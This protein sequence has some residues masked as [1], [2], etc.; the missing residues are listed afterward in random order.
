MQ[1]V[2][3]QAKVAAMSNGIH[4]ISS[5]TEP[6]PVT[7]QSCKEYFPRQVSDVAGRSAVIFDPKVRFAFL[8]NRSKTINVV[9]NLATTGAAPQNP[10][11][12]SGNGTDSL[13]TIAPI[14]LAAARFDDCF[15]AFV[16]RDQATTSNLP[17][18]EDKDVLELHVRSRSP[19][20]GR[21]KYVVDLTANPPV[22]QNIPDN[23]EEH[24]HQTLQGLGLEAAPTDEQTWVLALI[25]MVCPVPPG[26]KIPEG[27]ALGEPLPAGETYDPLFRTWFEALSHLHSANE[28]KPLSNT[29][30]LFDY[31]GEQITNAAQA[32]CDKTL[33]LANLGTPFTAVNNVAVR[34][35]VR[36][37]VSARAN[38]CYI[39]WA[40]NN[41]A[42]ET[43]PG[44]PPAPPNGGGGGGGGTNTVLTIKG[45][46]AAFQAA[47]TARENRP[48]SD[49]AA[50]AKR[51]D[52]LTATLQIIGSKKSPTG[53]IVL[54][55]VKTEFA[56]VIGLPRKDQCQ[57]FQRL[58]RDTNQSLE[59]R[60]DAIAGLDLTLRASQID[61][62]FLTAFLAAR[63]ACSS[64]PLMEESEMKTDLSVMHLLSVKS[65]CAT[66]KARSEA[67]IERFTQAAQTFDRNSQQGIR[68]IDLYYSGDQSEPRSIIT[69]NNWCLLLD[70]CLENFTESTFYQMTQ[71]F[72]KK[73]RVGKFK[74]TIEAWCNT[75]VKPLVIHQL[76]VKAQNIF[77]PL[78]MAA[79]N[80][81]I[82]AQVVDKQPVSADLLD[83]WIGV[84]NTTLRE[85]EDAGL[86]GTLGKFNSPTPAFFRFPALVEEA[87]Q[88]GLG[89][90]GTTPTAL[91][92]VP[93]ASGG[94]SETAP[95]KAR[96]ADDA[97]EKKKESQKAKGIF[98]FAADGTSKYPPSLTFKVKN[99]KGEDQKLCN[100]WCFQGR[101]CITPNCKH[102]HISS[103]KSIKDQASIKKVTDFLSRNPKVT[104]AQG[105]SLQPGTS[106]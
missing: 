87:K 49:S 14:S 105:Q 90:D 70:C 65:T 26:T 93:P 75:A 74:D 6:C 9:T 68:A 36:G 96:V 30:L 43:P 64:L 59:H 5:I 51:V 58:V 100:N 73:L 13:E 95:K 72:N 41:P 4:D 85:L 86:D 32:A 104:L 84:C 102:W 16:Q 54:G 33:L 48:G 1:L 63:F 97:L 98:C 83:Q 77:Y 15:V 18:L 81:T 44:A 60:T 12:Y 69:L 11:T 8:D 99:S 79:T 88:N 91:K 24:P 52:D 40:A 10:V 37:R 25:P 47:E 101:Y 29:T 39:L 27:L 92:R 20:G 80:T 76:L 82:V 50:K 34:T 89:L 22:E 17:I 31:A 3:N 35:A 28:S 66:F 42:P 23:L 21:I 46:T 19:S 71:L 62:A 7:T 53:A 38:E 67:D 57:A 2:L 55:T 106:S 45:L 103:A 78:M 56:G 61:H 94:A